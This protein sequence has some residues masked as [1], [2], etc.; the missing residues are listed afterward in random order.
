MADRWVSLPHRSARSPSPALQTTMS[1]HGPLSLLQVHNVEKKKTFAWEFDTPATF[2]PL[3]SMTLLNTQIGIRG[4]CQGLNGAMPFLTPEHRSFHPTLKQAPISWIVK[5]LFWNT[6][7]CFIHDCARPKCPQQCVYMA[8]RLLRFRLRS[9]AH[10]YCQPN[11][12][13]AFSTSLK[14]FS[15]FH[16]RSLKLK[17]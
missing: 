11:K 13:T 2:R 15:K 3:K 16:N 7:G 4:G 5:Y 9:L 1:V 17:T 14:T 12:Q 8:A 10:P 6:P